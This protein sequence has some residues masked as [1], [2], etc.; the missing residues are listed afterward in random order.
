MSGMKHCRAFRQKIGTAKCDGYHVQAYFQLEMCAFA[1]SFFCLGFIN[2]DP[3]PE[4]KCREPS[5]R[6]IE[7]R[8]ALPAPSGGRR[9]RDSDYR[10]YREAR[11]WD[12]GYRR[13]VCVL[14][15]LCGH[16]GRPRQPFVSRSSARARTRRHSEIALCRYPRLQRGMTLAGPR[17]KPLYRLVMV[18]DVGPGRGGPRPSA[19]QDR[20]GTG[21]TRGSI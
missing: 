12:V 19:F 1:H 18:W 8:P 16:V 17:T 15:G 7:T 2:R 6:C 14:S 13:N 20:L 10:S 3:R 5:C 21:E 4:D 9:S 11:S